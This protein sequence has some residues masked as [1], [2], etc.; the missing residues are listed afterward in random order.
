[1]LCEHLIDPYAAI[2]AIQ[3]WVAKF[4]NRPRAVS[5]GS[6]RQ[7]SLT[8]YIDSARISSVNLG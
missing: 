2:A 8:V 1:M 7:Q 3:S 4:G 5:H 6:S